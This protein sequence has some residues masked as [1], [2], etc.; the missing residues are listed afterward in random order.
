ML[1]VDGPVWGVRELWLSRDGDFRY[2]SGE[3]GKSHEVFGLPDEQCDSKVSAEDVSELIDRLKATGACNKAESDAIGAS[4]RT[5]S[6]CVA[7]GDLRCFC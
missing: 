5:L 4:A 2:R 6:M 1:E 3:A 7:A